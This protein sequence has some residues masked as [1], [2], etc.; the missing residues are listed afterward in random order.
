[1]FLDTQI[2]IPQDWHNLFK[3]EFK[4]KSYLQTISILNSKLQQGIDIFPSPTEVFYAFNLVK[5][6]DL[7]VVILGQ[8]PYHSIEFMDGRP[9]SHAHGLAFSIPKNLRKIPPSLKNIFKELNSDLQ[10]SIP[11]HGNLESWAKQGVLLLNST[12]TVEAHTPNS[13]SKIGWQSFTDRLIYKISA[14]TE[15]LVFILW[16]NYAIS[17]QTLIDTKKHLVITSAHPSPFSAN[18]GFF[19]SKPFSKTNE[20]LLS[21]NKQPINWQI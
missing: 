8:D 1:M 9:Q 10:V 2:Q 4:N 19:G 3:D 7:K 12:L 5:F 20:F 6:S 11:S 13:H 17:K 15:S 16:G 18:K 21:K 14:S